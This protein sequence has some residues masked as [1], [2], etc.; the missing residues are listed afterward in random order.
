MGAVLALALVWETL[1]LQDVTW[2]DS[3][4]PNNTF[5]SDEPC[6]RPAENLLASHQ[7]H[8]PKWVHPCSPHSCLQHCMSRAFLL[9]LNS[10]LEHLAGCTKE[11]TQEP[12]DLCPSPGGQ[13]KVCEEPSVRPLQPL[14]LLWSPS[15]DMRLWL[16]LM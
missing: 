11:P 8:C 4:L 14:P 5:C 13:E 3:A 2:F 7:L 1:M 9:L 15:Q 6:S 12:G 10:L 16:L